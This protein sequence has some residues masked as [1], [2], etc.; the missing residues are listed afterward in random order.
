MIV[1]HDIQMLNPVTGAQFRKIQTGPKTTRQN[2]GAWKKKSNFS[3][4]QSSYPKQTQASRP[5]QQCLNEV[6]TQF[7]G[8]PSK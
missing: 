1:T 4:I 6:I 3:Q 5:F 2:S 7:F 8:D